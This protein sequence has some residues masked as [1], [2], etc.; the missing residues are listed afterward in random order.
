VTEEK[1]V[2]ETDVADPGHFA[3]SF[4]ELDEIRDAQETM[5]NMQSATSD[6]GMMA[7]N[8]ME[9][10]LIEDKQSAL[11]NLTA[12]FSAKIAKAEKALEPEKKKDVLETVKGWFD[13]L[14][15]LLK[16]AEKPT[17]GEKVFETKVVD[18][19][20]WIIV[21]STNAF[22][23]RELEM[24][25]TDAIQEFMD[26]HTDDEKKGELWF[27][28]LPGAKFAD[29]KLQGL[30]G[31]MLVE[32]GPFD[33]TFVGQSFKKFFKEYPNGHPILAPEGWGAS[34]GYKYRPEDRKDGVYEWF[35]KHE[36]SVLPASMAANPYNPSYTISDKE[37]QS[38]MD[39][40]RRAEWEGVFGKPLVDA[41][42]ETGETKTA[43]LE[44]AG[45]E[46]KGEQVETEP[47]ET[48]AE[49]P[50]ETKDVVDETEN[51]ETV[52]TPKEETP[53]EV[54]ED[55]PLPITRDEIKE[56]LREIVSALRDE[57]RAETTKQV[58]ETVDGLNEILVPLAQKVNELAQA[59]EAKIAKQ[60]VEIPTAS[61]QTFVQSILGS[62]E[63]HVDGRTKYGRDKPEEAEESNGNGPTVQGVGLKLWN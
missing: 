50:E 15:T 16:P 2:Y 51:V 8:I 34:H 43:E 10:P 1:K 24:F 7:Q 6:F 11:Q 31:R 3:T 20:D 13:E 19:K 27:W 46:F 57:F 25:K 12:E 37:A 40:K 58:E 17:F 9:S 5:F 18:G 48:T 26:R 38:I 4:A 44:N 49:T 33:D 52:E 56:V 39:E 23:D 47:E 14:K 29:I 28:H 60:V 42:V 55:V 45:V 21:W 35:E 30:V 32:A 63:T 61:R 54:K 53:E 62:K 36:S 41:I 59:E 22:K